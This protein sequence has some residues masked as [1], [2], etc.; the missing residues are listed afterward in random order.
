MQLS[1]QQQRQLEQVLLSAF[2]R[3]PDLARLVRHGLDENLIALS[4]S[5]SLSEL[6]FDLIEWARSRDRLAELINAAREDNPA[7]P[8][9][10]RF[11]E[12]IGENAPPAAHGTRVARRLSWKKRR[13][14]YT[15]LRSTVGTADQ[16]RSLCVTIGIRYA[17]LEG[18]EVQAKIESL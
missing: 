11:A 6:V 9:L 10:R 7:H 4:N 5:E 14:L 18:D 16:L 8:Q 13:A 2:P 17:G 15:L 3:K 12:Q 1:G